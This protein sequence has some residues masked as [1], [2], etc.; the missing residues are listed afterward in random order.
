MTTLAH[1]AAALN[2]NRP[3]ALRLPL[4]G[5]DHPLF[6]PHAPAWEPAVVAAMR[7]L[8]YAWA[9]IPDAVAYLNEH[10]TVLGCEGVEACDVPAILDAFRP[11]GFY[12][13]EAPEADE[14]F[15][16]SDEDWAAWMEHLDRD[17]ALERRAGEAWAT[18]L[19]E[20]GLSYFERHVD[21]QVRGFVG[22]DA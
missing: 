20:R 22:H 6:A 11:D 10:G 5:R 17:E 9:F 19:H 4:T 15:E 13:D 7:D 16:P 2:P 12:H 3:A 8:G 1:D 21:D 14:A 18:E